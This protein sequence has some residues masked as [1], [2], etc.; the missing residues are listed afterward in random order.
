[1]SVGC[2]PRRARLVAVSGISAL[3]AAGLLV[4]GAMSSAGAATTSA[5]LN[6]GQVGSVGTNFTQSCAQGPGWIFVLPASSGD[7]FVSLSAT[8][9]TAGTVSGTVLANPKF[10]SVQVPLSD[11]LLSATAQVTNGPVGATFNLTHVCGDG[12]PTT[13]TT[14]APT[15]TTTEAPTTTTTTVAPTTTTTEAPTTTTTV[16]PTTSTTIGSE[17]ST[18]TTDGPTTTIAGLGSTVTTSTT[19]AATVA[20]EATPPTTTGGSTLPFTGSS[21]L[22]PLFGLGALVVGGGL[23]LASRRRFVR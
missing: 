22:P 18:T 11:T 21:N 2:G 13:T 4:L 10:A 14:V 3:C 8:F 6:A 1:M 16:A 17:G 7:A 15:T 19:A 20:T 9:Q 23:A 5:T 12:E